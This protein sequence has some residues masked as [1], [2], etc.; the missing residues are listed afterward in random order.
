MIATLSLALRNLLRN[1]RR[2][3][4]TLAAVAVGSASILL[5]GGYSANI[6]YSMETAYVRSGGHLQMQ[7]RDFN[8]Y[9][10]GNPTAYGIRGYQRLIDSLQ[11][12]EVLRSMVLVA[13]PTLQFG[14]IA[15]N[16][17]AGVSKT[18]IG[19]GLVAADHQR[20]RAWNHYAIPLESPP[21]PLAKAKAD[22]A[23]IGVGVA[24][25][26]QL[27][28]A[29]KV[30]LCPAPEK[31]APSAGPALPKDI[32]QLTDLVEQ[33]SRATTSRGTAEGPR[34]ELLASSSRGT[35]NVAALEVVQAEGQGFKELDDA[36]IAVHLAQAQRLVY[37]SGPPRA[38][39]VMVQLR[40]P[41]Q[42]PAA[43]ARIE[44]QLSK[45]SEG[46]P[47][48][49]FDIETLNP[50]FVQTVQLF[51]T[52]FGF[53]FAL[54]GGIVLFTVSNTM[55]AAVVERTVEIGTLRAM[56]LRQAGIRSLFVTEGVLLGAA[57]A[58]T[59]V[60]AALL[61]AALINA[62]GLQWLPPGSAEPLPLV[63]RVWGETGTILGVSV[64]LVL[65][66]VASAWWPAYRA[67]RLKIVDA[68]RHV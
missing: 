3:L 32:A 26:L 2:S 67:A 68:L 13:T 15:G 59:G 63:F 42:L 29:L 37:G 7:H 23:L 6:R 14:G 39:S 49:V 11:Q 43:R 1:R 52:I 20:M 53:I 28:A 40:R 61:L 21:L 30:E 34:I 47:L 9:G 56:G 50:F 4:A 51:A 60:I 17:S 18:V 16:Y 65:V 5:F 62:L 31:E 24:R 44:A 48:A 58:V 35:P 57:G 55:N 22:A 66:A 25:V 41:D 10:S 38:T 19:F 45:W 27:C 36:Y 46:Q 64:G 54:I 12:D 8:L 33:G